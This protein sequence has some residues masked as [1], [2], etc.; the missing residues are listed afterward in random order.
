M[1]YHFKKYGVLFW[2]REIELNPTGRWMIKYEDDIVQFYLQNHIFTKGPRLAKILYI[3]H[4]GLFRKSWI[5]EV[6]LKEDLGSGLKYVNECNS[7]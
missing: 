5:S 3:E 2:D 6:R 4:R 1:K 7:K